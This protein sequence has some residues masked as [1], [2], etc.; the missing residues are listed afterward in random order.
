M[1]FKVFI[2]FIYESWVL[3]FINK[4]LTDRSSEEE[5]GM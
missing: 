4:G 3:S 2:F 1:L 5:R